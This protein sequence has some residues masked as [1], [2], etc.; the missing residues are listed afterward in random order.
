MRHLEGF[1]LRCGYAGD[2]ATGQDALAATD[3]GAV[4]AI[5]TNPPYERPVMHALIAH[6]QRIAPTWLLLELDWTATK[7]AIPYLA[8]CRDIVSIGR[9]KWIS[10][11]P[12][13]RQGE[14]CLVPVRRAPQ[15]WAGVPRAACA[16]AE[17]VPALRRNLPA[18]AI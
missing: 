13:R 5:I 15:R 10:G 14:L 16:A 6:F 4:D 9:L 11:K 8:A 17:P 3:F 7:Q 1:G 12:A 18:A 2:L